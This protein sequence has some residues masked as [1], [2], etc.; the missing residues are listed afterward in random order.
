MGWSATANRDTDF[1]GSPPSMPCC[2]PTAQVRQK[3]LREL[4]C[5][6]VADVALVV[7]QRRRVADVG[8]GLLH[9]RHVEKDERLTKLTT[10]LRRTTSRTTTQ[11][12]SGRASGAPRRSFRKSWPSCEG[13]SSRHSQAQLQPPRVSRD[14]VVSTRAQT[15]Q[16]ACEGHPLRSLALRASVRSE[17]ER[18]GTAVLVAVTR[19]C[20]GRLGCDGFVPWCALGRRVE[21][22][23]SGRF[24]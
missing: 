19:T 4:T 10:C 11:N 18:S 23:A 21:S 14:R 3:L 17:P 13:R 15:P 22:V 2:A 24:A 20:R 8:L 7:E 6:D 16:S 9:R 5:R 1:T 12:C